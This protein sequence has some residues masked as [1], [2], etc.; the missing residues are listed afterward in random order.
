M[1][2]GALIIGAYHVAFG[3]LMI[4]IV[5][6]FNVALGPPIIGILELEE[7]VPVLP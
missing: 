5:G 4:G 7:K 6:A 1:I 3:A 2:I